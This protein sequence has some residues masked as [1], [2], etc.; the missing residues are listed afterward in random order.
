MILI[1]RIFEK[2][3]HIIKKIPSLTDE[4]KKELIDF[5]NRHPNYE[6]KINWNNWQNLTYDDFL[7]V[8]NIESKTQKRKSVKSK[9]IRGLKEG[10]DYL[11][12]PVDNPYINAYVPLNY[13]ASKFIASKYI[14][15]CEGDWCTAWQKTNEYW[16][17]YT[18]INDI[19]LIYVVISEDF[20]DIINKIAIAFDY[21]TDRV[22]IFDE[23]DKPMTEEEVE[24]IIKMDLN[25]LLDYRIINDAR[26]ILKDQ[27]L[28]I[29]EIADKIRNNKKLSKS[30]IDDL[31]NAFEG[32]FSVKVISIDSDGNVILDTD[33]IMDRDDFLIFEKYV[34]DGEP[35]D[36]YYN[37]SYD[38]AFENFYYSSDKKLID[39]INKHIQKTF[40]LPDFDIDDYSNYNEIQDDI[41]EIDNSDFDSYMNDL[42]VSFF[43]ASE[44]AYSDSYTDEIYKMY[45]KAIEEIGTNVGDIDDRKIQLDK[46]YLLYILDDNA[47][48][49]QA[50]EDLSDIIE[51]DIDYENSSIDASITIDKKLYNELLKDYLEGNNLI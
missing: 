32:P 9:G 20:S 39:K 8:L 27:K 28:P 10:E 1:R 12:I 4:Q 18:L 36:I 5:F 33:S 41:E 16:I 26:R 23:F 40:N 35:V 51:L 48:Y 21:N 46:T 14:G 25:D 34:I 29:Q 37:V 31:R 17:K 50:D 19:I 13:E 42:F 47:M 38:E 22:E 2:K 11:E 7:E 45:K 6:N 3:D 24:E 44:T 15:G 30:E 49:I 43:N